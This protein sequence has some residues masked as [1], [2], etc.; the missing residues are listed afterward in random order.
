MKHPRHYRSRWSSTWFSSAALTLTLTLPLSILISC[1]K[2]III[3]DLLLVHLSLKS[4]HFIAELVLVHLHC[5]EPILTRDQRADLN[6]TACDCTRISQQPATCRFEHCAQARKGL[7]KASKG[8]KQLHGSQ[9][10]IKTMFVL[11]WPSLAHLLARH[12]PLPGFVHRKHRHSCRRHPRVVSQ[13]SSH[14]WHRD[15]CSRQQ[16]TPERLRDRRTTLL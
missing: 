14:L 15:V 6:P 10:G 16:T 4:L 7:R 9:S 3:V 2:G 1:C 8:G 12:P 13:R 11:A 5:A